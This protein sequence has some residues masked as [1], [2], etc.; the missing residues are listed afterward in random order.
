MMPSTTPTPGFIHSRTS[1]C[2]AKVPSLDQYERLKAPGPKK[3]Q[4][5]AQRIDL[6][7]AQG[8][9]R[10]AVE[11]HFIWDKGFRIRVKFLGGSPDLQARVAKFAGLWLN[12]ANL[13][14]EFFA[15]AAAEIRVAFDDD[16]HWSRIGT[17]CL[18]VRD[19]SKQTMNLE[20]KDHDSD[21]E[22]RRVTLHQF[23]HA[24]GCIHER[25]SPAAHI[26]WRTSSVYDWYGTN[27]GWSN[28]EVDDNV[29]NPYPSYQAKASGFDPDSIMIYPIIPEFTE[30]GAY[31]DWN[32]TISALDM[33]YISEI[34]SKNG[35][36]EGGVYTLDN[37]NA[38]DDKGRTPLH[39]AAEAGDEAKVMSLLKNGASINL[40]EYTYGYTPLHTAVW[41]QQSNVVPILLL[42]GADK[43]IKTKAGYTARGFAIMW[44]NTE[45]IELFY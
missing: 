6:L 40:Q 7:V 17:D 43:E 12:Y 41:Y 15:N 35:G 8:I 21:D 33:K 22:V 23:G 1:I 19:Q 31:V 44:K 45:M 36:D 26:R 28:Q 38:R 13:R 4:E 9:G 2:L 20:L 29:I 3:T 5:N 39:I 24:I 37:V 27:M 42:H 30:D 34:Y 18:N 32:A 16:G 14:L 11:K 25:Q 10:L